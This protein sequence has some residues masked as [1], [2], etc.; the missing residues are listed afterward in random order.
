MEVVDDV[1]LKVT[2]KMVTKGALNVNIGGNPSAEGGGDDEGTDDQ[3]QS[4][5]D[6]VDAFNLQSIGSMDKKAVLAWYI[7]MYTSGK[8]RYGRLNYSSSILVPVRCVYLWRKISHCSLTTTTGCVDIHTFPPSS[9]STHT[10]LSTHKGP[11][12]T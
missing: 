3:A 10:C 12:G 5:N 8:C 6:V 7:V 11:R 4:V 9:F 2:T 1:V